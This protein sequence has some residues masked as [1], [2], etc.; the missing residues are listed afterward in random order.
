MGGRHTSRGPGSG[1]KP[2]TRRR[3]FDSSEPARL[4][5]PIF[6]SFRRTGPCSAAKM[7]F[8]A[9]QF[10]PTSFRKTSRVS[11]PWHP[12]PQAH[13]ADAHPPSVSH[14]PRRKPSRLARR[15]AAMPALV[16]PDS[17]WPLPRQVAPKC[18]TLRQGACLQVV[19]GGTRVPRRST[20]SAR[21]TTPRHCHTWSPYIV[22]RAPADPPPGPSHADGDPAVTAC[23]PEREEQGHYVS[24]HSHVLSQESPG[25]RWTS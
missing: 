13:A 10:S 12:D 1:R 19:C 6:V 11:L 17:C 9:P 21:R 16:T 3:I 14:H 20:R 2:G 23:H 22:N 24:K 18:A 7:D 4:K 25:L 15:S 5:A 8:G